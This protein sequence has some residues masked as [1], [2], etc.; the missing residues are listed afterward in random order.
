MIDMQRQIDVA[1]VMAELQFLRL[2]KYIS[3]ENNA[4]RYSGQQGIQ[5]NP[6]G[7]NLQEGAGPPPQNPNPS[8]QLG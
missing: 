8:G 3:K 1:Y 4:T 5:G 7:S 2:M 6:Q